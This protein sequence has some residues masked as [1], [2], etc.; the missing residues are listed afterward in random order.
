MGA[1]GELPARRRA[2]RVAPGARAGGEAI[3]R[4]WLTLLVREESGQDLVEYA[5]LAALIAMLSVVALTT[6]GTTVAGFYTRLT[7][8]IPGA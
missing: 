6:L 8:L 2:G 7:G 3:M 4:R 1:G 5:L